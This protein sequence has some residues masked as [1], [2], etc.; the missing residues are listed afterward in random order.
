MH[1][2][3]PTAQLDHLLSVCE[4]N[5]S[6]NSTPVPKYQD[7]SSQIDLDQIEARRSNCSFGQQ[8]Q[9]RRQGQESRQ[10]SGQRRASTIR[11]DENPPQQVE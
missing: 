2:I 3:E 6:A 8:S 10:Q 11:Q 7:Q 4:T 1:L 5:E 9:G